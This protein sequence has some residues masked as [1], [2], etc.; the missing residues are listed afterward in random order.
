MCAVWSK[1]GA[2]AM[3]GGGEGATVFLV[4]IAKAGALT[5]LEIAL[6]GAVSV[7]LALFF[8][9]LVV[10]GL[11]LG[12]MVAGHLVAELFR[13]TGVSESGA[14][15]GILHRLPN[16]EYYRVATQVAERQ[17]A[18]SPAYM[19]WA[20]IYTLCGIALVLL[21]SMIFYDKREI[22]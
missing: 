9:R 18:V 19:A 3:T 8:S 1:N 15:G 20:A 4:E 16:L 11:S 12:V 7:A 5:F 10:I 13:I 21:L 22:N 6:L 2:E 17:L 14:I